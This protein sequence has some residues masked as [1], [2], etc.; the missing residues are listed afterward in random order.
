M[1]PHDEQFQKVRVNVNGRNA[2]SPPL[3]PIGWRGIRIA[4]PARA[5]IGDQVPICGVYLIDVA[6]ER[7]PMR[8]VARHARS[9]WIAS[10]E[11]TDLVD[12]PR[13]EPL[14]SAGRQRSGTAA[15]GYFNPNLV[16]YLAV[17]AARYEVWIEWRGLRS[18][19][20]TV[21]LLERE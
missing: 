12:E 16:D 1:Q 3:P 15:G 8:L 6:A 18:N 10:A 7:S 11:L 4:A 2:C 19:A 5:T 20:V 9:G 13:A 17:E 21:E 14:E